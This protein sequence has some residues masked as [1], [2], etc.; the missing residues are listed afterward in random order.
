MNE[1]DS[2]LLNKEL[3]DKHRVLRENI[4]SMGRVVVAFSGG[5]DS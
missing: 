1:K 3:A 2:K 5:I 4:R